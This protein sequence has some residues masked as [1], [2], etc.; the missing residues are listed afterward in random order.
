LYSAAIQSLERA[1]FEISTSSNKPLKLLLP[2]LIKSCSPLVE[3][4]SPV[5]V[6]V[7]LL[8]NTPFTYSLIP[9]P[10]VHTATMWYQVFVATVELLVRVT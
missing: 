1:T 4:R 5:E 3:L 7:L 9:G 8:S 6:S 10:A 2:L